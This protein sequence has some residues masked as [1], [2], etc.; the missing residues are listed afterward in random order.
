[1]SLPALGRYQ[2]KRTF[3]K[4]P[5]PKGLAFAT[6]QQR[7]VVQ[8]HHATQLH[9]DFRLEHKGV[10]LSWAV[11][12]GPS[13]NPVDKRLAAHT[14]DHPLEYRHFEGIIPEGYGAGTVM[15]WDNGTFEWVRRGADHYSFILDGQKMRGE[16]AL[17]RLRRAGP[18]AWLMLKKKDRHAR[19]GRALINRLP[20]SVITGRTLDEIKK[21]APVKAAFIK[22]L[23]A[24]RAALPRNGFIAPM[25]P[26]LITTAF[27]D[28]EWLYEIKW[29]GFRGLAL[30]DGKRLL[31]KSRNN[32]DLLDWFPELKNISEAFA[33]RRAIIDGEVV[34]LD[35]K[36][37]S[38]FSDLGEGSQGRNIRFE[39]FDLLHLDG[40]DLTDVPLEKRKAL[41]RAITLPHDLVSYTDHIEGAGEKFFDETGKNGAE[42]IVAKERNSVYA[43]GKRTRTWYKIKHS[44]QQEFVISGWSEGQGARAGTIGSVLLGV[45][46][47]GKLRYAGRV[48]SG[49]HEKN[50]VPLFKQLRRLE[51]SKSPFELPTTMRGSS[52]THYVKPRLAAEVK[53]EEWTPD[54]QL[55]QPVF[56]GLRTDKPARE[57]VREVPHHAR[58]AKKARTTSSAKKTTERSD[59]DKQDSSK[60]LTFSALPN[61]TVPVAGQSLKFTNLNK[62]FWKSPR[63]LKRDLITYYAKIAP[64]LLPHLKDRPLSM[65]RYPDG[66]ESWFFYQKNAPSPR[67]SFVETI[68]IKHSQGPTRY[69]IVNN[70]ETL[71]WAANLA[72]LEIHP[73]YSRRGSLNNPDFVVFD[74]DPSKENDLALIRQVALMIKEIMDH[75][76]LESFPKSSGSRGIHVYV[77]IAPRF[78]YDQTKEFAK[79]VTGLV[80]HLAPSKTTLEFRKAKRH[81]V[82]IDYLQNI[83]GKTLACAYS[84]RAR[85]GATVSAPLTWKEVKKGF[86]MKDF[87]IASTLPRIQ[88]MGDLF[89]EVLTKKQD[90]GPAL[91]QL[92][93]LDL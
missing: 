11:P 28:P 42:G 58:L 9:Y 67:P 52:G 3:E 59:V 24:Q 18:K 54:S 48:G 50:L 35:K 37:I 12:K 49:F 34:S 73:W 13:D 64:I 5:E 91:R 88:E 15:V 60:T 6:S 71:L 23:S 84:L 62:T 30:I 17:V 14:E 57:I 27:S 7:F 25:K 51:Q 85:P 10:M 82:Y 32:K 38:H 44:L 53:F 92:G 74:L 93:K 79:K 21:G 45:Y 1:M 47:D 90:L 86:K 39:V 68:S 76:G 78:T 43:P 26:T 89:A 33:A 66:A 19:K 72:D 63:L 55:R 69:V 20:N 29:D 77:P 87:T 75:F 36:G 8:K 4:T 31:L 16:Y 61:Q 80:H 81:G 56:L 70:I 65:K 83:K 40:F 41:L 2:A 22:K 46:E